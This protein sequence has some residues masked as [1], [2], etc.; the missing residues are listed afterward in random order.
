MDNVSGAARVISSSGPSTPATSRFH[1]SHFGF[2]ALLSIL[3]LTFLDITVISAVLS[4]VQSELHSSVS[5][6]Q[7]VVGGYALAFGSLMLI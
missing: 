2:A 3:F 6:L 1:W 5:D 4:N 7:W